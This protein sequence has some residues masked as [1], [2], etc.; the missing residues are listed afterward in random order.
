MHAC[1]PFMF[2]VESYESRTL[3]L[4]KCTAN[5]L[6]QSSGAQLVTVLQLYGK[7]SEMA[8]QELGKYS[9]VNCG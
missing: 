4:E 5:G 7:E 3:E 9:S 8:E 1:K 2:M 6:R